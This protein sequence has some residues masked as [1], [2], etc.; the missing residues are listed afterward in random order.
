M[1]KMDIYAHLHCNWN[2]C[3]LS[4]HKREQ[5]T[6]YYLIIH[7]SEFKKKHACMHVYISIKTMLILDTQKC[8]SQKEH[9]PA[10]F[11]KPCIALSVLK[12]QSI[13]CLFAIFRV[14][15]WKRNALVSSWKPCTCVTPENPSAGL[16]SWKTLIRTAGSTPNAATSTQ[17]QQAPLKKIS[18]QWV[19]YSIQGSHTHLQTNAFPTLFQAFAIKKHPFSWLPLTLP[20]LEF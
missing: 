1:F 10:T 15:P 3:I 17:S 20:G 4:E 11:G 19:H 18:H 6:K 5:S 2:A 9:V 14:L 13:F 16:N 12:I 8:K 7:P